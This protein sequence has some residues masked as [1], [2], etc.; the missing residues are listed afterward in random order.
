M[1]FFSK[2]MCTVQTESRVFGHE[3]KLRP[4][5]DVDE[6]NTV[7]VGDPTEGALSD[8][9]ITHWQLYVS[10]L[11]TDYDIYLQIWRPSSL[12]TSSNNFTLVQ[13]THYRPSEL[14]FQEVTLPSNGGLDVK[15]GD[16][17]GLY[18]PNHNPTCFTIVPCA[19]TAQHYRYYRPPLRE[20][21]ALGNSYSF[22][23]AAA[24]EYACRQYSVR[25]VLGN[26]IDLHYYM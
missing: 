5:K 10:W 19:S 26:C 12:V 9:T 1:K 22:T 15:A 6:E 14:R 17:I 11:S 2:V 21:L 25:G 16:V 13:Q 24:G 18:F 7:I 20:P 23:T 3:A 8:G 4:Q